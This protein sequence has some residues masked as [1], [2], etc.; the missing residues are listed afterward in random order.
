[1]R[2]ACCKVL[3]GCLLLYSLV[4]WTPWFHASIIILLPFP[5]VV[6][7]I[8]LNIPVETSS[9]P[10]HRGGRIISPSHSVYQNELGDKVAHNSQS[11]AVINMWLFLAKLRVNNQKTINTVLDWTWKGKWANTWNF[12]IIFSNCTLVLLNRRLI[13]S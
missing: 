11:I 1:M 9:L 10:N 5:Y 3:F 6:G 2:S 4:E 13:D 7:G 12:Y 8:Y